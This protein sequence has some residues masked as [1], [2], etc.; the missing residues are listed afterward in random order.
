MTNYIDRIS[1]GK[2]RYIIATLHQHFVAGL[3]SGPLTTVK[4]ATVLIDLALDIGI[5]YARSGFDSNVMKSALAGMKEGFVIGKNVIAKGYAGRTISALDVQMGGKQNVTP[6]ISEFVYDLAPDTRTGRNIVRASNLYN[7][8]KYMARVNEGVDSY[9]GSVSASMTKYAMLKQ[10]YKDQG[11]TRNA[12]G[13]AAYADLYVTEEK[14]NDAM[15]QARGEIDKMGVDASENMVKRRAYEIIDQNREIPQRTKDLA[16]EAANQLT[17]KKP[18]IFGVTHALPFLVNSIS[19][20]IDNLA[21]T[22]HAPKAAAAFAEAAKFGLNTVVPFSGIGAN[23]TESSLDW[24]PV[25]GT[26]KA[27]G[28]A[29]SYH[30]MKDKTGENAVK[31]KVALRRIY[32][33][34]AISIAVSS[35]VLAMLLAGDD[36]DEREIMKAFDLVKG[37]GGKYVRRNPMPKDEKDRTIAGVSLDITASL[38]T[39][40]LVIADYRQQL[41]ENPDYTNMDLLQYGVNSYKSAVLSQ[42]ILKSSAEIIDVIENIG[43]IDK[44]KF[45]SKKTAQVFANSFLPAAG[46][47]KQVGDLKSPVKKEAIGFFDNLMNEGGAYTT[48]AIDREKYDWRGRN[49]ATGDFYASNPRA[50]TT[51]MGITKNILKADAI[52]KWAIDKNVKTVGP[53]TDSDREK[54]QFSFSL[55]VPEEPGYRFMEDVEV[56][57]FNKRA[58]QLLNQSLSTLWRNAEYRDYM[59]NLTEESAQRLVTQLWAQAKEESFYELNVSINPKLKNAMD[60]EEF[61]NRM[62]DALL[63]EENEDKL[64]FKI[65]QDLKVNEMVNEIK[66]PD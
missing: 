51:N 34:Q 18:G 33:K 21:K 29:I 22:K 45:V 53:K 17:Y 25:Y 52:D 66:Y 27:I 10:Y 12:A 28:G 24:L 39:S 63:K 20:G 48:W 35:Y 3:I 8:A 55:I 13:A 44:S 60:K 41:K 47:A 65:D 14:F 26:V 6:R 23:V 46:M 30:S 61:K 2:G 43:E 32:A 36:D 54:D 16:E 58:S 57:T 49:Y 38:Q 11:M 31:M 50:F 9:F 19:R 5:E 64:E 7:I 42:S 4:N 59:E 1:K 37:T 40:L 62:R 56:Y 15:D